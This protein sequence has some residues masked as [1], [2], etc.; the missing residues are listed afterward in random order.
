M[1][2]PRFE[3]AVWRFCVA[4]LSVAVTICACVV[5]DEDEDAADGEVEEG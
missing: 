1:I 5:E 2:V 4:I 3:I